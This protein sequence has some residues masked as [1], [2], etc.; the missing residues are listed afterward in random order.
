MKSVQMRS[1][2]WPVVSCI[3]TK[4]GPEIT[5]Y[6]DT[7]HVV[8]GLV[9]VYDKDPVNCDQTEIIGARV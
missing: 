9:S 8:T 1:Y 7:F 3:R 6:L 2:F 4:Y 5:P